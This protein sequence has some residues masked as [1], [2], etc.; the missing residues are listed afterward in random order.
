M[1]AGSRRVLLDDTVVQKGAQPTRLPEKVPD[2]GDEAF[3]PL[4]V[5]SR[6]REASGGGAVEYIDHIVVEPTG[7]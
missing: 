4:K 5:D 6:Q 1:A 3:A 7:H 2:I